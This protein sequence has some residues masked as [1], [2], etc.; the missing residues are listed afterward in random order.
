MQL[1]SHLKDPPFPEETQKY[2]LQ[3]QQQYS[4][5]QLHQVF[6][7]PTIIPHQRLGLSKHSFKNTQ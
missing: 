2:G 1:L 6:P 7:G 4:T 3:T 5:R